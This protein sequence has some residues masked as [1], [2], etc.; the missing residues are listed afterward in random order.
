MNTKALTKANKLLFA[1][2]FVFFIGYLS[3]LQYRPYPLSY[4]VKIIPIISLSIIAFFNIPG[5]RGKLIVVGLLFSAVGDVFLAISGKGFFIYGLSAFGLAH[6]MYIFALLKLPEWKRKRTFFSLIFVLY[7][8]FIGFWL[9]PNIIDN[10]RFIPVVIYFFLLI[11][12]GISAVLGRNNHFLIIPGAFLFMIS[13]SIIAVNMFITKVPNS[14]FWIMLT[15]FPAQFL[16]TYG[17]SLICAKES[18]FN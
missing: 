3:T 11:S 2:F 10:G 1:S 8:L 15:Y 6:I 13:D 18:K 16:I 12:V 5:S 7:G 17:A 4:L 9:F 14:S